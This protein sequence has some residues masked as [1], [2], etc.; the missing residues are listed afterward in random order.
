MR[1][2]GALLLFI[3]TLA[4]AQTPYLAAFNAGVSCYREQNFT[5]A[6]DHFATAA[7]EA[8]SPAE[9]GPALFNLGNAH[10]FDAD[11]KQA[12]ILFRE[13]GLNGVDPGL[14]S[15]NLSFAQSL[16]DSMQ[17]EVEDLRRSA[18][19]AQ[20]RSQAGELPDELSLELSLE[21]EQR[22][23]SGIYRSTEAQGV[24]PLA[25]LT[26]AQLE[27][28]VSASVERLKAAVSGAGSIYQQRW[29]ERQPTE[30]PGSTAQLLN[31]LLPLELGLPNREKPSAVEI[32]GQRPW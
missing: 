28:L 24:T 19:K 16:A 13:A 25:A 3:A 7:W 32:E 1:S 17:Q 26:P 8:Q 6:Q 18:F 23:A 11:F 29:I 15:I 9:R 10:F 21:L 22:L 14:V 5:C 27:Q 31:R 30:E 20:W 2:W 12:A 4:Q